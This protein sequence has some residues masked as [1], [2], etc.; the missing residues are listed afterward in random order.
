MASQDLRLHYKCPSSPLTFSRTIG[1][2][3]RCGSGSWPFPTTPFLPPPEI[4]GW[5]MASAMSDLTSTSS[6][7]FNINLVNLLMTRSTN[8]E[9]V[10]VA[11]ATLMSEVFLSS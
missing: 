2:M 9:F 1:H 4:V 8:T 11:E 7:H 10:S 6:H 5:H 3:V